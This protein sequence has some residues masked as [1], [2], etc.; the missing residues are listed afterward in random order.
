MVF[1]SAALAIAVSALCLE[2]PDASAA[3]SGAR[4][5]GPRMERLVSQ[6]DPAG[7]RIDFEAW[8]FILRGIV[9]DVGHS[10]REAPG[11]PMRVTGSRLN[12]ESSSRYRYE[13]NRL[14]FHLF[15]D[16]HETAIA[17]YR[18]D[19]EQ[20]PGRVALADLPRDEQ[21][22]YWLNLHNAI[23]V[24]EM[25]RAYPLR[26]IDAA[27]IDGQ[28]FAH[29]PV[30]VIEG[31]ALSLNDIRFNIVQTGWRDPRV[32]Y[33]LF[34][35]AVGG[36]SL[37]DEAFEGSR[38]WAQLESNG[39]EF[40][41]S[42]RGV[43]H[44]YRT[45]RISELYDRHAALFEDDAALRAHLLSL[46]DSEVDEH[47]EEAFSGELRFSP[48]DWSVSDMTNGRLGCSG[49]TAGLNLDIVDGGGRT[50]NAIDCNIL[51]PQA[52]R[53]LEVVVERRLEFIRAGELGRVTVR[54]IPTP[55]APVTAPDDREGRARD[56]GVII[57]LPQR[58]DS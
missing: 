26:D 25:R 42:L 53:L 19:L 20:L 49:P 30:A 54:D 39:R 22:A 16:A 15:Q 24:D 17:D 5:A 51:P 45:P 11:R 2:A 9:F 36:P 10:D 34:L 6:G 27:R 8:T 21:L 4:D 58:E 3:Q 14:A 43:D 41:N 46:A 55:D 40:V 50:N 47:I 44:F 1:R 23:V 13:G 28:P 38:V 56:E 31:V 57:N 32:I 37:R 18:A 35:G 29:A 12:L 52:A 33:G 48:F 7:P